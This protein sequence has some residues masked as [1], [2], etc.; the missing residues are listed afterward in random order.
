MFFLINMFSLR[1]LLSFKLLLLVYYLP[2]PILET[3]RPLLPKFL[4]LSPGVIDGCLAT[5]TCAGAEC[6][7]PLRSNCSLVMPPPP[8][9]LP[10]SPKTLKALPALNSSM[11][12]KLAI[13]ALHLRY[14]TANVTVLKNGYREEV[15][16]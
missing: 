3:L 1:L 5:C 10:L 8:P 13:G 11:Q 15:Y 9:S 7:S 4:Y 16:N 12:S 6:V 14:K 2:K